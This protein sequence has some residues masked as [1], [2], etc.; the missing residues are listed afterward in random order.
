MHSEVT[1]A[2]LERAV[3]D[4]D[5]YVAVAA[6][7]NKKSTESVLIKA[8]EH[9]NHHVKIAA[10]KNKNVTTAVYN[11]ALDCD[12]STV[13]WVVMDHPINSKLI[14]PELVNK[15]S[16]DSAGNVRG[17]SARY[18]DFSDPEQFKRFNELF[19]D[20][21]PR[22]RAAIAKDHRIS[23]EQLEQMFNDEDD[24]V[25]S[26]VITNQKTPAYLIPK[27]LADS[28]N[29]VRMSAL[30]NIHATK[31]QREAALKDPDRYVRSTA[32]RMLKKYHS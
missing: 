3:S 21:A 19:L 12:D 4:P 31:S 13:R 11:K 7:K 6:V 32:E 2:Q 5:V 1:L 16:H 8:L 29:S 18:L 24:T 23:S 10:I 15:A 30:E 26:A 27:A 9:P 28:S 22:A 20:P 17:A 25:R 14:T